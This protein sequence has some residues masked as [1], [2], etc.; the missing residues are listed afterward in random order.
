LV[1]SN[2]IVLPSTLAPFHDP[3]IEIQRCKI[4][5]SDFNLDILNIYNPNN[6]VTYAEFEYYINQIGEYK[7]LVGDFNGHHMLWN[8]SNI[9]NNMTGISLKNILD[10]YDDIDLLT[11]FSLPTYVSPVTGRS[12]TL[13][14]CFLSTNL[15]IGATAEI[16][17]CLGSDHYPVAI[18]LQQ[19][20]QSRE[21]GKRPKWKL[22]K[23]DWSLWRIKLP[24]VEMHDNDSIEEMNS[25]LEYSL[26]NSR[27]DIE[28]S[29]NK[30]NPK[31]HS[32]W[33][34]SECSRLV[35][36][37]RRAK[38]FIPETPNRRKFKKTQKC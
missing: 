16:G 37:R 17:P 1:R 34:N 36:L 35:A 22:D 19:N 12:S 13:D 5:F 24:E 3:K 28:R 38:K 18:K 14:L 20:V 6:N 27:Y 33:W 23:V 7:L 26:K 25:K 31:F 15:I 21:S 30:Y 4:K 11:P 9:G 32:P 8:Q 2:I 10:N 29:S